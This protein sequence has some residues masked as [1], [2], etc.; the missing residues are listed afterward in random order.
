MGWLAELRNVTVLFINLPDLDYRLG[1]ERAQEIMRDIQSTLY[2]YEGSI[3]K[4]NVDEKGTT[5]LAAFGLPPFSHEDDALR[6][7]LAS[8]EIQ[9]KLSARN[10]RSNIGITSGPA[11]CGSIGSDLRREYTLL[12]QKVNLAVRLMQAGEKVLGKGPYIL[13]DQ[14]TYN[15]SKHRV[16]YQELNPVTVKGVSEPVLIFAPQGEKQKEIRIAEVM[17]GR[18]AERQ[19]LN[20][21]L[22]ALRENK[23][24][25]ARIF[26][27][28]GEPGIGKSRL[29]E[30]VLVQARDLGLP[31]ISGAADAI[32][33]STPYFA[34]RNVF[35]QMFGVNFSETAE[36]RQ[37]VLA[38]TLDQD[39]LE[40]RP[41][42]NEI[43]QVNFPATELTANLEGS[44][45]AENTRL[46]LTTLLRRSALQIPKVITI[47]DAHW[48]DTAS[49]AL[50]LD[51]AH[52][53][54]DVPLSLILTT[55]PLGDPTPMEFDQLMR[56]PYSHRMIVEGLSSEDALTL[57]AHSLGVNDLPVPVR[58][59]ILDKA[60]GHPFFSEELAYALRDTGVLTIENGTC[61]LSLDISNLD[62][63]NLP[64]TVQGVITSRIDRLSPTQQLTLRVASVIGR[65]FA[66]STLSAIH[67]VETDLPLLRSSLVA[68]EKLNITPL[69]TPEP[70]LAYIFKHSIT[71]DVAYNLMLF[72]QRRQLHKSIAEWYEQIYALDLEPYYGLLAHHYSL[73]EK[74]SKA[75]FY[76]EKAGEQTLLNGAYLEAADF[77]E[78]ALRIA[79]REH[80]DL[81]ISSDQKARWERLLGEAYL[82]LGALD[83]SRE[84]FEKAGPTI[85]LALAA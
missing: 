54:A 81:K 35:A 10:I 24:G 48:M 15:R 52:L 8:L 26:V 82:G 29:L 9:R 12:G 67:P 60:E 31:A 17:V 65:V 58:N 27:I 51:V 41:L 40:R 47:E 79:D 11:F 33:K 38:L 74:S 14:A 71:R 45:L 32:E 4:L 42:L 36:Q 20:E 43:L 44:I 13:S 25:A 19:Q 66:Y 49:W 2:Y 70:D 84:H 62:A 61:R 28:E 73:A 83:R 64:N 78:E 5:L 18:Y 63:L 30:N 72:A 56:L 34:W 22:I 39:L 76:L 3:N 85:G 57:V 21:A 6:G 16:N 59:L 68:L 37:E 1:L 50:L 75:L 46:L 69:E 53:A 23:R 80:K 7:T 55:R 77:F